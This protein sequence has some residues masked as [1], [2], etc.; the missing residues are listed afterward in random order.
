MCQQT[1]DNM[2]TKIPSIFIFGYILFGVARH[3]YEHPFIFAVSGLIF[4]YVIFLAVKA[5]LVDRELRKSEDYEPVS[6]LGNFIY[7]AF[8]ILG[9]GILLSESLDRFAIP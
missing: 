1:V 4:L 5:L 8:S 3:I 9:L 2:R 6:M 7:I